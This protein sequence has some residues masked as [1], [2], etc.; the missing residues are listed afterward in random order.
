MKKKLIQFGYLV[1]ISILL[2]LL[3]PIL[4]D[5]IKTGEFSVTTD[6]LRIALLLG[7]FTPT[8]MVVSRRIKNN[9]LFVVLAILIMVLAT[10]LVKLLFNF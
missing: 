2:F 8:L 1:L 4:F 5:W 10:F 7:V 6:N 9:T 3:F